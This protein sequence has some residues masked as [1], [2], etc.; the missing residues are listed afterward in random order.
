MAVK[1]SAMSE[2]DVTFGPSK[3]AVAK[4]NDNANAEEATKKRVNVLFLV[5]TL[6]FILGMI[7]CIVAG[8]MTQYMWCHNRGKGKCDYV[9]FKAMR[10]PTDSSHKADDYEKMAKDFNAMR[11]K[12]TKL[13]PEDLIKDGDDQV[14][15]TFEKY[16]GLYNDH[17]KINNKK[18]HTVQVQQYMFFAFV[19]FL[20]SGCLMFFVVVFVIAE[21]LMILKGGDAFD[22]LQRFSL[23]SGIVSAILCIISCVLLS[24]GLDQIDDQFLSEILTKKCKYNYEAMTTVSLIP[25]A[26]AA[27]F[28]A[29]A[30]PM[31]FFTYRD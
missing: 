10:L 17:Q 2:S 1:A 18:L 26:L 16:A 23:G 29:V 22:K 12:N 3:S 27:I 11:K 24:V 20:T 8:V 13:K 4:A 14:C 28:F 5:S 9:H 25:G 15:I 7:S 6:L 21:H 31:S 30:A 19:L